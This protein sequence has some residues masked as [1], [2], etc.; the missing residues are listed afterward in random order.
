MRLLLIAV[1]FGQLKPDDDPLDVLDDLA[2]CLCK[3][4]FINES[5]N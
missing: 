3:E 4:D 1:L 5:L 2:M